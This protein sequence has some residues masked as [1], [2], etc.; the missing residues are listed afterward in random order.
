MLMLESRKSGFLIS[1][2]SGLG[3][4]PGAD[5]ENLSWFVKALQES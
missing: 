2:V 5:S 1:T 3:L 4:W